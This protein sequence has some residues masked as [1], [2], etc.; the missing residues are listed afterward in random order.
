M[1]IILYF[2]L[3][4]ISESFF[5]LLFFNTSILATAKCICPVSWSSRSDIGSRLGCQ[6]LRGGQFHL[7]QT[8]GTGGANLGTL[9]RTG[10]ASEGYQQQQAAGSPDSYCSRGKSE[11]G[12]TDQLKMRLELEKKTE[13]NAGWDLRTKPGA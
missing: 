1:Q 8:G 5:E 12:K 9:A 10:T 6:H 13:N 7:P 2:I 3:C 4:V 11:K